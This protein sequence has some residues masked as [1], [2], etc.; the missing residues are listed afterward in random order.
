MKVILRYNR[1]PK[2][3][4]Q[5]RYGLRYEVGLQISREELETL[6]PMIELRWPVDPDIA[7]YRH[8]QRWRSE[9]SDVVVRYYHGGPMGWGPGHVDHDTCV[10][11]ISNAQLVLSETAYFEAAA[12]REQY[13]T[14][15]HHVAATLRA[16]L[17]AWW[18]EH[19]PVE[20][21]PSPTVH[22]WSV[23]ADAM[24]Q[25]Q[26]RVLRLAKGGAGE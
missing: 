17:E 5:W 22:E 15:L 2:P 11:Y 18:V 1:L 21:D 13:I 25:P 3:R 4:G 19:A 26:G 14:L 7:L 24:D 16:Y 10:L 8:P 9:R 12:Q 20:G 6:A 23:P